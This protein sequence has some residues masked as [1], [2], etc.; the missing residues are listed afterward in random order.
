MRL[1]IHFMDEIEERIQQAVV[2]QKAASLTSLPMLD[3]SRIASFE[4]MTP[5]LAQRLTAALP[6]LKGIS[7]NNCKLKTVEGF[8]ALPDLVLVRQ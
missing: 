5:L 1:N 8:D 7:L 4:A 6:N 2:Q 3:L